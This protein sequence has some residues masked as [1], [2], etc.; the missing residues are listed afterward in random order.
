MPSPTTIQHVIS[1]LD[2]YGLCRQLELLVKRQQAVGQVAQV[3][4]LRGD[5][6]VVERFRRRGINVRVLD[7]RWTHDPFLTVRLAA[8]L[9]QSKF[10]LLH[11][12]G[13]DAQRYVNAVRSLAPATPQTTSLAD[14]D[15]P[16]GV[17]PSKKTKLSHQQLLDEL[18]LPADATL[19]AVAG[20]LTRTQQVDEAIWHFELVRTLDENTRLLIFGDG[21]DRHRLERFTRLTSEPT[22]VRFLGYRHDYRALLQH[23]DLFWHTASADNAIPLTILEAM[24]AGV[25]VVANDTPNCRRAI[26]HSNNG[27]LVPN[28]DR[29][30]F[31]RHTRQ[32]MHDREHAQEMSEAAKLAAERYS[33][34]A[35]LDAYA[36]R[37]DHCCA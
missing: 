26:D 23:V 28:N 8:L 34:D 4:A 33:I 3:A 20:P 25:P 31:A 24:F 36:T 32:L 19:I 2:G 21:P 16:I 18:N 17:A 1:N 37:Y 15:L 5:R 7:R 11:A 14:Q 12:W 29:A 35:M 9:R 6:P 13:R 10:D 30:V 22:A 27:Y